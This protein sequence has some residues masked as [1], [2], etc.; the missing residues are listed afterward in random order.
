MRTFEE[1]KKSQK[2]V[3]SMII[4]K[5]EEKTGKG[6]SKKEQKEVAPA[7]ITPSPAPVVQETAGNGGLSAEEVIQRNREKLM[8][9][10]AGKPVKAAATSR[11]NV[12]GSVFSFFKGLAGQSTLAKEQIS[13]VLEKMKEHLT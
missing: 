11:S 5:N 2:T 8:R 4:D 6:K 12:G 1:S 7:P 13:P 10:M 3:A 9:K